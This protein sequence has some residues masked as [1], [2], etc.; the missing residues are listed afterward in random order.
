MRASIS[1]S[2]S[3]VTRSNGCVRDGSTTWR[4]SFTGAT[5]DRTAIVCP[6]H[7]WRYRRDGSCSAIPQLQDPTRVPAKARATAYRCRQR[8]GLLWVA[9][10][11]PCWSLPDVSELEDAHWRVVATGPFA[12]RC[13]ASRQIENF[14]D[15]GHFA[16]VHEG[17]LGDPAQALR[18]EY[19]RPDAP[20]TED[21]PVFAS[22]ERKAPTRTTRYALHLP[23]TI[24]EHIDWGGDE[25]MLYFFARASFPRSF[26][27]PSNISGPRI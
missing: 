18:Y 20:N 16:F 12:W 26:P 23:Y 17:L 10:D 14:T 24:V 1:M 19:V 3:T 7:G 21:F 15:F 13:D 9:L 2:S 22:E 4:P 5:A 27:P 25:K 11:D 6:Y 8:Y